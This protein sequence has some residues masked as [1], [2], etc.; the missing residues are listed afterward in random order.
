MPSLHR[1]PSVDLRNHFDRKSNVTSNRSV[2]LSTSIENLQK[3]YSKEKINHLSQE[4]QKRKNQT[5]RDL[6]RNHK[7]TKKSQITQTSNNVSKLSTE[8]QRHINLENVNHTDHL[9]TR[10][11][12][13]GIGMLSF[14]FSKFKSEK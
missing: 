10:A 3:S 8:I 2:P 4:A 7:D 14:L 12:A 6:S 9:S 5:T 13:A 1:P 11:L